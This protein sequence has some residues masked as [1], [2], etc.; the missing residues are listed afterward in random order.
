MVAHACS[1]SYSGGWGRRIAW[2]RRRRL[3][4]AEIMPLHSSLDNNSE[5]PPQ[6]KKKKKKRKNNWVRIA[7]R[8]KVPSRVLSYSAAGELNTL[9]V[10]LECLREGRYEGKEQSVRKPPEIHCVCVCLGLCEM[11][12]LLFLGS[13]YGNCED[14]WWWE[15]SLKYWNY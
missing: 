10:Y 15:K 1:P 12:I 3:R 6:K 5:T 4:W 13:F 2:T 9:P 11:L 7:G 14:S 8:K